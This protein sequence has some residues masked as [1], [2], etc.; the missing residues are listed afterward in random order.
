ME[1]TTLF[2]SMA[3]NVLCASD[4]WVP[5]NCQLHHNLLGSILGDRWHVS[6]SCLSISSV[7]MFGHCN[8]IANV[9]TSFSE[10]NLTSKAVVSHDNYCM[11]SWRCHTC[12]F[13]FI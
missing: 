9:G 3:C 7:L 10:E 6:S 4:L 1:I 5:G 2:F 8:C 11:F 13:W 12:T